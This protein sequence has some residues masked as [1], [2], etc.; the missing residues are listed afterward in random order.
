MAFAL[1]QVL[2]L[3]QH[4]SFSDLFESL[5][6]IPYSSN[7]AADMEPV[8]GQGWTL[9]Y[10]MF[11]YA[12]FALALILPRRIGLPGLFVAFAGIVAAGSWVKGFSD[13]S[14]ATTVP[15]FLAD[16]LILLFAVG[17]G[18]G[19]LKK[20]LPTLYVKY[21]FQIAVAFIALQIIIL[22]IFRIP[23]RVSFPSSIVTW[24]PGIF[25]VAACALAAPAPSRGRVVVVSEIL[26]DA[27]YSTY[28]F[29]IFFLFA[30]NKV[31][32]ISLA[33]AI[34][35]VLT[36]L[37]GSTLIGILFYRNVERPMTAFFRKVSLARSAAISNQILLQGR[38]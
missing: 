4:P 3:S 25:A 35:Y 26:G 29:H 14:P 1:Y 33:T 23:P 15:A 8:L 5:T 30:L 13:T 32:P 28:I 19:I 24:I 36:S 7:P 22:M 10:E 6:F 11:F 12:L 37:I 34:P 38:S 17:M 20:K 18:I 31:F 27:S 9:N 2:S 21:P 16:P